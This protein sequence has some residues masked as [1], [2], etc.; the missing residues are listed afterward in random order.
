MGVYAFLIGLGFVLITLFLA[1][2]LWFME[3][4][5]AEPLKGLVGGILDAHTNSPW[6]IR[7]GMAVTGLF[8]WMSSFYGIAS[9]RDAGDDYYFRVGP[10][11]ISVRIP[12]G[13]DWSMCCLRSA[14]LQR[15]AGWDEIDNLT[16]AQKKQ[17]GSL[18]RNAG[19][20]GALIRLRLQDGHKLEFSVDMF[21]EP[22]HIIHRRIGEA[23]EMVPANLGSTAEDVAPQYEL[24]M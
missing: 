9:W 18:S 11:G 20:I 6:A 21:R 8:G 19:N 3:L 24:T 7:T 2:P 5:K 23:T 4:P 13:I 22:G 12:D 17:F 1:N 14:V 15:D 10:G 16:V